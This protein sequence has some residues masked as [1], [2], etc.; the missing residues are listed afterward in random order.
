[1]SMNGSVL[2]SAHK[3]VIRTRRHLRAVP[4]PVHVERAD[5]EVLWSRVTENDAPSRFVRELV[6][7]TAE[8]PFVDPRERERHGQGRRPARGHEPA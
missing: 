5:L 7:E 4:L 1:M 3:H 8:V 6:A 2:V